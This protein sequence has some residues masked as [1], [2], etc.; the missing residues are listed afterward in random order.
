MT[1]KPKKNDALNKVLVLNRELSW[2]SFNHRVLQEASDVQVP[3]LERMRFLGIFSNNLDEF[4]R[5]RV[6]TVKRMQKLGSVAQSYMEMNPEECLK[7][8]E[9]RVIRLQGDFN[10]AQHKLYAELEKE[11]VFFKNEKSL[12]EIQK[13]YAIT[14]YRNEVASVLVPVILYN[15]GVTP[16]VE[17]KSIYLAIRMLQAKETTQYAMIEIPTDQLARFVV[18]PS[19]EGFTDM[20]MLDDVIRLA[21]PEI[22]HIFDFEE[23]EAY[24]FKLTRDAELDIEEDISQSMM[25]K[26]ERSIQ[27]RKQGEFVRF[28][29]DEQMPKDLLEF[30]EKKFNLQNT[31]N[32]IAGGRYHN[33]KDFMNVPSIGAKHLSYIPLRPLPHPILSKTRSIMKVVM[34]RDI[35]LTY[36]YQSFSYIIDL[37]R[38]AAIDP[39]VSK[40]KI[41]IYRVAEN[42]RVINALVNAVKN[43]KKVTVVVELE[44]RFDEENNLEWSK[45]LEEE[46]VKVEFGVPGLKVHSKLILIERK[47]S[48]TGPKYLAHIGT[49]NFHEGTAKIYTD[50]SLLTV[51]AGITNEVKKVFTFLKNNYKREIYRHLMVSPFNFRRKITQLIMD[52][53]KRGKAGQEAYILLKL[54]NLVDASII[55]KLYLASQS[56]VKIRIVV[57]GI[58][59]LV[60]G[61]KG[62]SENIRVVS[63][64]DRFLEHTR[65]FIFGA[66]GKEKYFISSADIM[67]RNLDRRVEVATPVYDQEIQEYLRD[68]FEMSYNDQVK[69]R[70]IDSKMKNNYQGIRE[71]DTL[72][73]QQQIYLY[74]QNLL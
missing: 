21:L 28:I 73:S 12:N 62:M 35:M 61:V 65:L 40:I 47:N 45:Y 5:V 4:F 72:S 15:K 10:I 63:V 51:N 59:T 20:I 57:R 3:L 23:I 64:V 46:G 67:S 38:E 39:N 58:C 66:G 36:P 34:E 13:A 2:L 69:G 9:K 22:F 8:I 30:L 31:P 68:L 16:T 52:E 27:K 48:S 56:G 24:T 6:A 17:D 7:E 43:G 70:I 60:P 29:H 44:A 11:G 55:K 71:E 74:H 42:S 1:G 53:I 49:G 37:L 32:Q 18:L 25:E 54:N 41:N 26:L 14:Y 33:F 50:H 19:E